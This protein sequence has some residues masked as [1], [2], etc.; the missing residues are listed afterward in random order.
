MNIAIGADHRGYAL[1]QAIQTELALITWHDMGTHSLERADY[2]L[3]A[4]A[5]VKELLTGKVAAGVLICGTGVGMS[6]AANRHT[7]IYAA[8]VW[9]VEIARRAKEE[10]YANILVIP[11]DYVTSAQAVEMI[12]A[13]L[14]AQHKEGR[15]K[16]RIISID[17][18]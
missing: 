7:G 17:G 9:S 2:P 12:K 16:E 4:H 13:W 11:A 5:I 10:D 18:Q 3:Y 8:L 15:Y 6:I 1:K 14:K